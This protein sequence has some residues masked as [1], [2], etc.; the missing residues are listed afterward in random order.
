MTISQLADILKR[1]DI[2]KVFYFHTD[3]FEPWGSS[4]NSDTARAVDNFA[5]LSKTTNF[6]RKLSL[7]YHSYLPYSLDNDAATITLT[8]GDAVRFGQPTFDQREL[9]KQVIA[10]LVHDGEHEIHVHIHHESWTRNTGKYNKPIADWLHKHSTDQLD[11]DRF[12][13]GLRRSLY[14]IRE[15]TSL[16]LKKWA[17]IHGNWALAGSDPSICCLED[18]IQSLMDEG[19]YGDFTFP[20]GR[21]HCDPTIKQVPYSCK[22]ITGRKSY[23]LP[24]ADPSEVSLGKYSLKS[25]DRFLIWNSEIKSDYSSLDYYYQPNCDRFREAEQMIKVWLEKSVVIDSCLY[26]KTHSHSM[27]SGY[28]LHEAGNLTP[29]TYGDVVKLFDLLSRVVDY[30]KIQIEY[31]TVNEIRDIFE[32]LHARPTT[33]E[34]FAKTDVTNRISQPLPER[35]PLAVATTEIGEYCQPAMDFDEVTLECFLQSR[36]D[37]SKI[38]MPSKTKLDAICEFHGLV[39]SGPSRPFRIVDLKQPLDRI[40]SQMD[41]KRRSGIRYAT[42]ANV[43]VRLAGPGDLEQLLDVW[44]NGYCKKYNKGF[45]DAKVNIKSSIEDGNLFVAIEPENHR[46][47]AF[48]KVRAPNYAISKK[49]LIYSQNSS[50]PEFLKYKPNELLIWEILK[51]AVGQGYEE[52]NLAGDNLFKKQFTPITQSITEWARQKSHLVKDKG[53]LMENADYAFRLPIAGPF[54]PEIGRAYVV[55]PATVA[56]CARY[57]LE[58]LSDAH[59]HPQRS[60]LLLFEDFQELPGAHARHQDII[61]KGAGLYSHWRGQLYFSTTDGSDP[62]T[63]GRSYV[64]K[65]YVAN[66]DLVS[67]E[68]SLPLIPP[69][70]RKEGHMWVASLKNVGEK[71]VSIFDITSDNSDV[72]ERSRLKLFNHSDLLG[73]A[74]SPHA[75]IRDV[76][77]GA[78][79]HWKN[80]IIFST[81]DGSDP[82]IK[83]NRM[84]IAYSPPGSIGSKVEMIESIV[85]DHLKEEYARKGDDLYQWYRLRFLASD[86]GLSVWDKAIL[87]FVCDIY[88]KYSRV[89]DIGAG[90]GQTAILLA[91]RRIPVL[92][93][94]ANHEHIRQM[95]DVANRVKS[96]VSPDLDQFFSCKQ[97]LFPVGAPTYVNAST[98]LC[99]VDNSWGLS[100][101]QE[102]QVKAVMKGAGGLIIGLRYFFKSRTFDETQQLVDEVISLGFESPIEVFKSERDVW[103]D[104]FPPNRILYFKRRQT[105]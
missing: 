37:I 45:E 58:D 83:R 92:A 25:K 5:K 8:G 23:D 19:C 30:A 103:E 69:Y 72:P 29:H 87:R 79:S 16:P 4:I 34:Q 56:S 63:N 64:L 21:S 104:N 101:E 84:S 65:S 43:K 52:F 18:E 99:F 53:Y 82:N 2:K 26:I 78:Y 80:A 33:G 85:L 81:V 102:A 41:H 96:I 89:V 47:I 27:W 105:G 49:I 77:L 88:D 93:I 36:K 17:F 90:I 7:F 86:R 11:S 68:C 31:V 1:R 62:N 100:P 60:S 94:E 50:L 9:A 10:P 35:L 24:E 66:D 95:V 15:E 44:I 14:A 13:E 20:A 67:L 61:D 22:P 71:I 38:W 40:W 75:F 55:T 48:T 74:N 12:R 76:G 51:W 73:P 57:V 42:K 91:S 28:R 54:V 3:H 70:L 32:A 97:D 98:L 39:K 6:S 46:I 59:D